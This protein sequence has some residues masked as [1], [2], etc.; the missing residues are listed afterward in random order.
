MDRRELHRRLEQLDGELGQIAA[1]DERERAI[2]AQARTDLR[3]LLSQADD[4]DSEHY[5]RLSE[6]LRERVA[7]LEAS[8]PR[9]TLVLGQIVDT[10][11][12]LGL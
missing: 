4:V 3:A 6:R 12:N 7:E 11:A 1:A 5:A 8:Y 2:L 9:A 10:L